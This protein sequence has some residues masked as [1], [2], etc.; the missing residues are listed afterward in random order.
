MHG[1][2]GPIRAIVNVTVEP[3]EK[4]TWS[5]VTIALDFEVHGMGK[6]SC[7]SSSADRRDER[8]LRT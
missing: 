4:R 5:R 1:L 6:C 8:C 7:H 2:D 3:L